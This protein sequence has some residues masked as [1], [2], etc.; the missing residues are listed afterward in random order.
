MKGAIYQ[1]REQEKSIPPSFVHLQ[2]GGGG[3]HVDDSDK[4]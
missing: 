1:L 4:S 2:G 3:D